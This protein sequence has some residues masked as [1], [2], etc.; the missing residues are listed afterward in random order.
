MYNNL[1]ST[2]GGDRIISVYVADD[3]T[4]S[5]TDL[6]FNNKPKLDKKIAITP[7]D[8]VNSWISWNVTEAIKQNNNAELTLSIIYDS[9]MLD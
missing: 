4:W 6:T 1:L 8:E 2:S 3:T 7:I 5:E 9:F